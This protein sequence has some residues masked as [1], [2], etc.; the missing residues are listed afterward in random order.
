MNAAAAAAQAAEEAAAQGEGRRRVREAAGRDREAAREGAEGAGRVR[1]ADE[2]DVDAP[3]ARRRRGSRSSGGDVDARA[4]ARLARPPGRAHERA[5][6][7]SSARGGA[8]DASERMPRRARH[9]DATPRASVHPAVPPGRPRRRVR[10]CLRT[11]AGGGDATGVYSDDTLMPEV[12]ALPYVE[13]APDLAFVVDDGREGGRSATCSASPTPRVRR[14]VEA[15][16][17][18]GVRGGIRRPDRRPATTRASPRRSSSRPG[19]N[20]DRMR[21]AELDEYP[22]H[23]H[24]DL[25]PE[26]QGQGMGRRLID[27]LRAALADAG[28]RRRAPRHGCGEHRRAGVLRPARVPRAA[29]EPPDAPLLGIATS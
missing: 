21:I 3:R 8:G 29:V 2:A 9:P 5:S 14:V 15:R 25:L 1:P 12:F 11:A 16:V 22:A 23:L 10:I 18:A 27:T 17:D 24:I 19:V 26:L 20:P 28:R 6:R 7:A 4:G 13:Y